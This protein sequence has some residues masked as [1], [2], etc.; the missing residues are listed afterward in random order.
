[1]DRRI[2]QVAEKLAAHGRYFTRK[3]LA[4][5][6]LLNRERKVLRYTIL[7]YG[8]ILLF[9]LMFFADLLFQTSFM[10]SWWY[11][12]LL[13]VVFAGIAF[14]WHRPRY[15]GS[16]K[17]LAGAV[18]MYCRIKGHP[19]LVSP[20]ACEELIQTLGEK[21]IEEFHPQNALI[22]ND[23]ELCLALL[24][25]GFASDQRC[26]VL[27]ADATPPSVFQYFVERQRSANP[28][29][30][31]ALHDAGREPEQMIAEIQRNPEW[32]GC[33]A[34]I[35][36]G[37][38]RAGIRNYKYGT[39][40]REGSGTVMAHRRKSEEAIDRLYRRGWIYPLAC[41]PAGKLMPAIACCMAEGVPMLSPEMFA[42]MSGASSG[43]E[44]SSH[45]GGS[46]FNSDSG[47]GGFDGDG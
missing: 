3:Q 43:G 32:E 34:L 18:D 39:W 30:V 11:P 25:N 41:L 24:L 19:Y 17:K 21:G 1:M 16:I 20:E 29:K 40:L 27:A 44:S 8:L 10:P 23:P 31:F 2:F 5:A 15:L 14:S 9:L 7:R 35:D 42:A 12:I 37:I 28:L 36:L 45:G 46:D 6:C 47:C 33:E 13:F 22:V 38:H 26:L 4:C